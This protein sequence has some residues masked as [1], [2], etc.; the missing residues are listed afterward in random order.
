MTLDVRINS[1]L[2]TS[3]QR[4]DGSYVVRVQGK[5]EDAQVLFHALWIGRLGDGNEALLDV[6]AEHDLARGLAVF[7]GDLSQYW[8]VQEVVDRTQRAV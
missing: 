5:A 2:V 1:G 7:L 4:G 8:G 6:P 3:V